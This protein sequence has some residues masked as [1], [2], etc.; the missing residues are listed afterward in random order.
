[1]ADKRLRD[2]DQIAAAMAAGPVTI[3]SGAPGVPTVVVRDHGAWEQQVAAE[4]RAAED[5]AIRATVAGIERGETERRFAPRPA[6]D[7]LA[8][9]MQAS[10]ALARERAE[11][12]G[13]IGRELAATEALV[14]G[15]AASEPPQPSAEQARWQQENRYSSDLAEWMAAH[16]RGVTS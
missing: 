2:P 10:L 1:M 14:E 8:T 6:H 11:A 9:T 7:E 16:P 15:M 5:E 4:N 13:R 3:L 12:P